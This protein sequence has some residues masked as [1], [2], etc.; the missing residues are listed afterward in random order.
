MELINNILQ[1]LSNFKNNLCKMTFKK[2][3]FERSNTTDAA[4]MELR[5]RE[6]PNSSTDSIQ[7]NILIISNI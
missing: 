1:R 6:V 5:L 3:A 7:G 4:D 2:P